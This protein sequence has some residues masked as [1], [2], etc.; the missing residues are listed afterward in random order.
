MNWEMIGEWIRRG[1]YRAVAR[2]NARTGFDAELQGADVDD[3]AQEASVLLVA[4]LA[5]Y[6]GEPEEPDLRTAAYRVAS[7]STWR[8][9]RELADQPDIRLDPAEWESLSEESIRFSPRH[10]DLSGLEA[11]I[12]SLP[13]EESRNV[14]TVL[15]CA[16]YTEQEVADFLGCDQSR[17]SRHITK[18]RERLGCS[19]VWRSIRSGCRSAEMAGPIRGVTRI[20]TPWT[21][22]LKWRLESYRL[23]DSPAHIDDSP[24]YSPVSPLEYGYAREIEDTAERGQLAMNRESRKQIGILN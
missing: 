1:V 12:E 7:K 4:A 17:V 24:D 2:Y 13:S 14:A 5:D 22:R 20:P 16:D 11:A 21:D 3:C 9:L 6:E 19:I 18:L 10:T 23:V 15:A 8:R